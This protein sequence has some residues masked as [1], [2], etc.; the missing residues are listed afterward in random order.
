MVVVYSNIKRILFRK[1]KGLHLIWLASPFC[2]T[3]I[4]PHSGTRHR[5][6]FTLFRGVFRAFWPAKIQVKWVSITWIRLR[7]SLWYQ[8]GHSYWHQH[9]AKIFDL[10][11]AQYRTIALTIVVYGW[12]SITQKA[13]WVLHLQSRTTL[14]IGLH[15]Q[16]FKLVVVRRPIFR[17]VIMRSR[18][19]SNLL[20]TVTD[21]AY[22]SCKAI[23]N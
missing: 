16:L 9:L 20:A 4:F 8:S 2:P 22:Q 1:C 10:W 18:A 3:N 11:K 19:C 15:I 6:S 21:R 17:R 12:V 14:Q 5:V 13:V 7:W 23:V